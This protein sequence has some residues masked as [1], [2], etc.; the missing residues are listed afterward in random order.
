[1]NFWNH[2][3][4]FW[5]VAGN[6]TKT[7]IANGRS[8]TKSWFFFFC[9]I[10]LCWQQPVS[11]SL[12]RHKSPYILHERH[13]PQASPFLY[14]CSSRKFLNSV[15]TKQPCCRIISFIEKWNRAEGTPQ[16]QFL[17]SF[18][19]KS[20]LLVMAHHWFLHALYINDLNLVINE[21]YDFS[22]H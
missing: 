5:F 12:S 14:F 4:F 8:H 3:S 19:L 18:L 2:F 6:S 20:Q 10:D 15:L 11:C 22:L 1:M 21:K 16:V 17:L 9:T 13:F 7:H